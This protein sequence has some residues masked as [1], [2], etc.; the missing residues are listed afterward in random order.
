QLKTGKNLDQLQMT[1]ATNEDNHLQKSL[2]TARSRPPAILA[3]VCSPQRSTSRCDFMR[4]MLVQSFFRL[5]IW[6]RARPIACFPNSA[7]PEVGAAGLRIR[8]VLQLS[9]NRLICQS[10]A[11]SWTQLSGARFARLRAG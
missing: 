9:K 11:R 2:K 4:P 3:F 7:D 8:A 6:C 5:P 1:G 10:S